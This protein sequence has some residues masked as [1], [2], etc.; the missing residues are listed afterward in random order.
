MNTLSTPPG[1]GSRIHK[2]L[3][4][5]PHELR[6]I[7]D[8]DEVIDNDYHSETFRM[9]KNKKLRNFREYRTRRLVLEG[10][11]KLEHGDLD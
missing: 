9:L 8:P 10:W 1:I 6:Y 5:N 7:L 11:D 3:L 2:N 4:P